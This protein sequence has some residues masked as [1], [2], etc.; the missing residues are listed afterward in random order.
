LTGVKD[1]VADD[2]ELKIVL[3]EAARWVGGRVST[4]NMHGTKIACMM[5][6]RR[7]RWFRLPQG[8]RGLH[9]LRGG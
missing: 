8:R 9:P 4:A 2:V 5:S 7:R 6:R 3:P 1:L